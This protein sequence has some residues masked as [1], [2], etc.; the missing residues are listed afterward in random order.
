LIEAVMA[1]NYN[2]EATVIGVKQASEDAKA[3]QETSEAAEADRSNSGKSNVGMCS[4]IKDGD[5]PISIAE[6]VL[7]LVTCI[8]PNVIVLA[9]LS[10]IGIGLEVYNAVAP[11]R[12][13]LSGDLAVFLAAMS[14]VALYVSDWFYYKSA[15]LQGVTAVPPVLL[16]TAGA[17]LK[18]RK[19]PW[20]PLL[21]TLF[22]IPLISAVYRFTV[23]KK[24][25]Q[26]SFYMCV[27]AA[28]GICGIIVIVSFVAW[29]FADS[30]E[31][32][33]E[34]KD[35]LAAR[36]ENIYKYVNKD[37][38][39]NYTVHC[40]PEDNVLSSLNLTKSEK[41]GVKKACG[42]A[43]AVWFLV[44]TC[45]LIA[46]ICNIVLSVFCYM[47]AMFCK[48]EEADS[49]TRA[50][51]SFIICLVGLFACMYCSASFFSLALSSTFMAFFAAAL[52]VLCVF[53]VMEVGPEAIKNMASGSK[54]VKMLA[55][56]M[57]SDWVR[58]I[59]VGA[60]NIFIPIF[61]FLNSMNQRVRKWKKTN[62]TSGRYTEVA[63]QIVNEI[64]KWNWCSIFTK[65]AILGELFFML[66]VGISKVT[67]IFLSWLCEALSGVNIGIVIVLVFAVGYGM[68]LLPP[69][70]GVPVYVFSGIVITDQAVRKLGDNGFIMGVLI[71]I[72]V[73]FV[74]KLCACLGQYSIGYFA[75]KNL[76]VQQLIAVDSVPT[77]A[78]EMILK[79]PGLDIGKVAI[80]IGGPDW[81]TS[82]TCGI[83]R[84]SIPQML[85][86]TIPVLLILSPCV[87]AGSFIARQGAGGEDSIW[88]MLASTS[89]LVAA[90][91]QVAAGLTATVC[92]VK[93]VQDHQDDL[94][95]P[96]PEHQ[97][98]AELT[99][100]GAHASRIYQEVTKWSNLT[101]FDKVII[102][103]CVAFH[104]LSGFMFVMMA[105]ACFLPFSVDKSIKAPVAEGGLGGDP[106][107]IVINPMG[108]L[109]LGLFFTAVF[110]H[111][112]HC[113]MMGR[114]A[115]KKLKYDP[116]PSQVEEVNSNTSNSTTKSGKSGSKPRGKE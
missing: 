105:E 79:R 50:L 45:P 28:T 44:W 33:R 93:T 60:V 37:M 59:F 96:R 30:H 3:K 27:S 76:K 67:Y 14:L 88:P 107:A 92:I 40:H 113:Q 11:D 34:T 24:V 53:T 47:H 35:D 56:V 51:K 106:F 10:D 87:L 70:P 26:R 38:V 73:G 109:A 110:L 12:M 95:K 64:D 74:N 15:L 6:A 115:K 32:T 61:L 48:A 23:C 80:L 83:L 66:Q 8:V 89:T 71:A 91:C 29:V 78:I 42:K 101:A 98:V 5:R 111:I 114:R 43:V 22:L 99:R 9:V 4:W 104:L 72:A 102:L 20:A 1:A 19:Y 68:F 46:A 39:L 84:L 108:Y 100:K 112:L 49:M 57:R 31:W 63:E 90:V 103:A 81:P 41:S 21:F 7:V 97:A 62:T 55:P 116:G 77:K 16:I 85:L 94:S 58:A 18:G 65:V 69:V 75:G 86:G 82:V 17:F 25:L 2:E 52:C 36:S 54:T 13:S